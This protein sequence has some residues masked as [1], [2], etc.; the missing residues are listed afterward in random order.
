MKATNEKQNQKMLNNKTLPR[1][2]GR[3][4]NVKLVSVEDQ[5]SS[6]SDTSVPKGRKNETGSGAFPKTDI[7]KF[8]FQKEEK[9][10]R[11]RS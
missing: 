5:H 4:T 2:V 8:Q 7:L 9:M 1:N 10:S 6:S 11:D 3:R